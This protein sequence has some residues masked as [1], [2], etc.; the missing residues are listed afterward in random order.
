M[1]QECLNSEFRSVAYAW[2]AAMVYI[3]LYNRHTTTRIEWPL[4]ITREIPRKFSSFGE[5]QDNS[6]GEICQFD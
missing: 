5:K 1:G 6:V 2:H 4:D 3:L